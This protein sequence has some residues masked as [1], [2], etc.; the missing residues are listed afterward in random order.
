ML[1]LSSQGLKALTLEE[2]EVLESYQDVGGVWSVG[3][4]HTGSKYAQP[5][6]KITKAKSRELLKGDVKE[7]EE[8]V[9][10][11]VKVDITQP[12]FD[13][14]VSLVFNIGVGAFKN[15]TLL[16]KLNAG[17]YLGAADQFLVWR[18]VGKKVVNGLVARRARERAMFLSGLEVH[19]TDD[20]ELES[21][22]IP[23]VP[24][25]ASVASSEPV[26]VL[27]ATGVAGTLSLAAEQTAPLAEYSEYLKILWIILVL[28]GIGYFIYSRKE[29]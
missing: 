19:S 10:K 9:R 22:I 15:S 3:V 13:A 1:S 11:Y 29:D 26:R 2:G 27:G 12:M 14:L 21:N 20:L 24:Q 17:D 5:G 6:V 16:K 4:G 7:A 18:K 25:K 28:A 23:D 8:A